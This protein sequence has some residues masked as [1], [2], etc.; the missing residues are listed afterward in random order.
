MSGN[1]NGQASGWNDIIGSENSRNDFSRNDFFGE[2]RYLQSKTK[3]I[4]A[5]LETNAPVVLFTEKGCRV[6]NNY[7][8]PFGN[9]LDEAMKTMNDAFQDF[10]TPDW[11]KDETD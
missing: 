9:K 11:Y 5:I 7:N 3:L 4:S 10:L 2:Y 8:K 1:A 6:V